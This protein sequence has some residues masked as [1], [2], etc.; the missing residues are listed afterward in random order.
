M[1]IFR[2]RT[3]SPRRRLAAE[4]ISQ[5]ISAVPGG[6][7]SL[8]RWASVCIRNEPSGPLPPSDWWMMIPPTHRHA[9]PPIPSRPG[10]A[11]PARHRAGRD[12]R[13][14]VLLP[15]VRDV[16]ARRRLPALVAARPRA[17]ER[18]RV[19]VLSGA[20]PLLVGRPARDRRADGRA[21]RR[22]CRRDRGLLVGARL[23]R[24]R[25]PAR[26]DRRRARG[27]PHGR[28]APR[29]LPGRTVAGTVDDVRY[30]HGARYPHVLRLSRARAAVTRLDRR[31]YDASR[32][33][34]DTRSRRPRSSAPPP[35]AGFAGVYTYDIVVYGGD[36]FMRL[37]AQAHKM[38]LI[39]A[40][41]VGPGYDARRGSGDPKVKPRRRTAP[42]TT[43]CGTRRSSPAPTGSPSP[44]TTS[45][46]RARR[47][48]PRP[49]R[50]VAAAYRYLSYEGAWGLHGRAA[51]YAYLV[52]TR[53]WSDVFRSTAPAQPSTKTVVDVCLGDA[54]QLVVV[55]VDHGV[56][57]RLEAERSCAFVRAEAEQHVDGDDAALAGLAAC[58]RPRARVA[59][60]AGRCARSSRSRCTGRSRGGRR[61]RPGG[62]RRR[63]SPRSSGTRR[64][65]RRRRAAGRARGRRHAWRARSSTAA[66]GNRCARAARSDAHRARRR[67]SS[68]SRGCSSACTCRGSSCSVA[69]RPSSESASAG[70]ARTEWGA[71]PTRIPSARSCSSC[72][73]YSA[74]ESWRKRG[75]RLAGSTRRDRRTRCPPPRRP[76]RPRAPPRARGSGIRRPPCSRSSAAPGRRG[77]TRA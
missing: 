64:C 47:S 26:R 12:A 67:H 75:L 50:A 17:P 55:E 65:A 21:A 48:S 71:T 52:R 32:G 18:H 69:Y 30:L 4:S 29:A 35:P 60:R 39:C 76:R 14:G 2:S 3:M 53:Y 38:H 27:R 61:A 58:D 72:R 45:G 31:E 57:P 25:T 24:G 28:R 66:R 77:R 62:S 7:A 22:R 19:G 49:D 33:G 40:P 74:T 34:R 51:E 9:A 11:L 13:L 73:R 44:R 37:C 20:R 43:T 63:G 6:G 5:G 15:L 46:T 1:T 56:G 54:A 70:H 23:A 8:V 42:P 68:I 16:G 10:C 59:P 36:K 41:S